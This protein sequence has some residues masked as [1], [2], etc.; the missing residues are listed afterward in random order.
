MVLNFWNGFFRICGVSIV[1]C[2]GTKVLG[3]SVLSTYLT[4]LTLLKILLTQSLATTPMK[5]VQD[6]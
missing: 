5:S 2:L 4:V 6:F 3:H 1:V